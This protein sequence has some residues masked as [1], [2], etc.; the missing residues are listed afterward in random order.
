MGRISCTAHRQTHTLHTK[1]S[2]FRGVLLSGVVSLQGWS[3]IRSG[4]SS[5]VVFYQKQSVVEGGLP[6]IRSGF[7]VD[8]LSGAVSH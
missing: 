1:W 7:T 4:L 8:L 2:L 5:G 6:L 3:F